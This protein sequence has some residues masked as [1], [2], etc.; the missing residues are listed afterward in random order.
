[1]SHQPEWG[2]CII[3]GKAF[4]VT[5]LEV[6]RWECEMQRDLRSGHSAVRCARCSER[7]PSHDFAWHFA[8]C[9]ADPVAAV[10]EIEVA[11]TA[12]RATT[13]RLAEDEQHSREAARQASEDARR[14]VEQASRTAAA[15]ARQALLGE[16]W[17]RYILQRHSDS[18]IVIYERMN[19]NDSARCWFQS[20]RGKPARWINVCPFEFGEKQIG[21]IWG[22]GYELMEHTEI[23]GLLREAQENKLQYGVED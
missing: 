17:N 21:S 12:Q 18:R 10:H 15:E 1:M 8:T 4:N 5:S 11:A 2:N 3:C 13:A 14:A 20:T 22:N 9:D 19:G 16:R 6:H 7:F 23:D